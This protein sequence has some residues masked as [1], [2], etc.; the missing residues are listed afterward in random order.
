MYGK[1]D[2]TERF[3]DGTITVTDFKTGSSKTTGVIEKRD[4]EGRLSAHL[5]QLAMYSYLIEGAEKGSTVATS[6]LL[7]IEED[8]KEKKCEFIRRI[9][10]VNILTF[11]NEMLVITMSWCEVETG[12]SVHVIS[13]HMEKKPS[14]NTANG[15]ER[16]M[17]NKI[18][19]TNRGILMFLNL[20]QAPEFRE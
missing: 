1:V 15:R 11:S 4:G 7:Y 2:L 9:F 19:R 3:S 20:L 10:L 8:P 16:C 13:N 17:E 18:P 5:R 6:K 12:S 14:A